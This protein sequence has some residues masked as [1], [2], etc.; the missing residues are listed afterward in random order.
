MWYWW[1]PSPFSQSS[2]PWHYASLVLRTVE[3]LEVLLLEVSCICG[4]CLPCVL[5]PW[6]Q[7][8]L[9]NWLPALSSVPVNLSWITDSPLIP[10][11]RVFMWFSLSHSPLSSRSPF[12]FAG[13]TVSPDL[14]WAH[15]FS[16]CPLPLSLAHISHVT[17]W[18]MSCHILQHSFLSDVSVICTKV[19]K[20]QNMIK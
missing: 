9:R 7:G 16:L 2:W 15:S 6:F 12:S 20:K 19:F 4:C 17:H 13:Q 10:Q 1:W 5:P 3:K 18:L 8:M 14:P 11:R